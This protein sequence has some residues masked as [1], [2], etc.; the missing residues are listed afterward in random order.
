MGLHSSNEVFIYYIYTYIQSMSLYKVIYIYISLYMFIYLEY[1]VVDIRN[2]VDDYFYESL[3]C[4]K[5]SK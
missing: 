5:S 1:M 3:A 4:T 2:Y